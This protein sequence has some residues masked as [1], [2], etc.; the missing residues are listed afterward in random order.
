MTNDELKYTRASSVHCRDVHC[1][2]F[3]HE[4]RDAE[5][6]RATA[7]AANDEFVCFNSSFVI[8]HS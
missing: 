4:Q 5:K 8:R 3:P 2:D 6:C 1:Q 7:E